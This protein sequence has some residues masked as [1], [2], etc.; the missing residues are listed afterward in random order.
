MSGLTATGVNALSAG[1]YPGADIRLDLTRGFLSP[2]PEDTHADVIFHCAASFADDT[3]DGIRKNYQTNA[4]GCLWVLELARLLGCKTVIYAG[5]V[6]SSETLDPDNYT[7]YGFT[8]AQA[9]NLL[10]WGMKRLDGQFCSLRFSQIYDTNGAC[11]RH[12][13]WFGRIIAYAARGLDLNMPGSDG[14]RNFLHLDDAVNLM[15]TAGRSSTT[16]ILDI[17]H[18]ESLTYQKLATTTYSI[19]DKGGCISIDQNKA[20]FRPINFPD[21]SQAFRLLGYKPAISIAEGI[22]R[23]RDQETWVSFGPLDVT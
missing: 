21:S 13:P 2:I 20:P 5:S 12:Q 6:S 1:R 22:A 19:F 9:E 11:T 23:I 18:P 15:L 7:S 10:A 16:G 4:A 14:L 8:K 3:T 17:V